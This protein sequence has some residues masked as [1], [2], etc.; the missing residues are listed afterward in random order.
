MELRRFGRLHIAGEDAEYT[1]GILLGWQR[2]MTVGAVPCNGNG[3]CPSR[4]ITGQLALGGPRVWQQDLGI[5]L[6]HVSRRI[7]RSLSESV[8]PRVH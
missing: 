2:Y 7:A 5:T 4:L 6:Q 8:E 3:P 1:I